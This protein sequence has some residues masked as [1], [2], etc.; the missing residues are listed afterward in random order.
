MV[1]RICG[2][3]GLKW[4]PSLL[5]KHPHRPLHNCRTQAEREAEIKKADYSATGSMAGIKR[6]LIFDDIATRGDT[7]TAIAGAI[8]RI[9]PRVEVVGIALGKS[10]R[11]SYAASWGHT[12][13]NEHVPW[14][15][16]W[17]GK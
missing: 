6:V 13:S 3:T 7:L 12:I 11:V 16:E 9:S 4:M 17:S 10:E 8:K 14:E 1:A 2:K 15:K 5:S